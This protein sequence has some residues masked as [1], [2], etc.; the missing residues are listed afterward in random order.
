[1]KA[2]TKPNM[3][4]SLPARNAHPETVNIEELRPVMH[5]L[6]STWMPSVFRG[7]ARLDLITRQ[8]LT[9]YISGF[10]ENMHQAPI[11]ITQ[12]SQTGV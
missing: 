4:T 11:Q 3:Q 10:K 2:Q 12:K 5:R 1:M 8:N 6:P 7:L 9:L